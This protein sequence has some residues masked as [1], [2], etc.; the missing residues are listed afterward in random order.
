VGVSSAEERYRWRLLTLGGEYQMDFLQRWQ[1]ALA[2]NI[3]KPVDSY[4]KVYGAFYDGFSLE[5]GSG[6]YWRLALPLQERGD[7]A[8]FSVE[9][10]YQQQG[11]QQSRSVV[12]TRN[13][14]PQSTLAYQPAS[15]RRELGVT[16]LWRF[17]GSAKMAP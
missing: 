13:G 3:G 12:L 5:P 15:I 4:Q 6:I 10:Y 2:V 9:P 11:M 17:A 14:V 7:H 1:M 16:V 8:G